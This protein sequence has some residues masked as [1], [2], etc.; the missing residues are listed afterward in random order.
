MSS[1]LEIERH[2]LKKSLSVEIESLFTFKSGKPFLSQ[3]FFTIKIWDVYLK[4]CTHRNNVG[5]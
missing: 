5:L 3:A 2:Y 4:T 1:G